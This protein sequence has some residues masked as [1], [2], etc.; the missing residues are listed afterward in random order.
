MK[1]SS[2]CPCCKQGT[3]KVF[4]KSVAGTTMMCSKCQNF[5]TFKTRLGKVSEVIV[6]GI[7][8]IASTAAILAFFDIKDIHDLADLLDYF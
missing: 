4:D 7:G 3:L 5:I 6:P 2:L 1:I 8:T